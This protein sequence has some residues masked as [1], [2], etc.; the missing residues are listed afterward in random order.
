MEAVS[1][2]IKGAKRGYKNRC[3]PWHI[4]AEFAPQLQEQQHH[5]VMN[6]SRVAFATGI[7]SRM[8]GN[9]SLIPIFICSSLGET[10]L[11]L[12]HHRHH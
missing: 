6:I 2:Y 8:L 7:W 11:R 1:M 12:N 3:T 5:F 9:H 10:I 4:W